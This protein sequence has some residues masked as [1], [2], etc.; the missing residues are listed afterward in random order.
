MVSS[1]VDHES[2]LYIMFILEFKLNIMLNIR[3]IN[4][5]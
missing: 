2:I 1:Y 5:D 3:I 4:L